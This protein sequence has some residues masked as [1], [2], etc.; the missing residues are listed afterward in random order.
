MAL[1]MADRPWS[2]ELGEQVDR[3]RARAC[4]L[5]A[6]ARWLLGDVEGAE[7]LF[8]QAAFQLTGPPNCSERA[9]YCQTLARLRR[10]QGQTDE[11]SRLL[12]RATRLY[13]ESGDREGERA[14]LADLDFSRASL[15]K[16]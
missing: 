16:T 13:I 2:S 7:S 3:I 5:A 14:C 15:E 8:R 4:C 11:A 1:R 6:S 12:W 9:F 10:D